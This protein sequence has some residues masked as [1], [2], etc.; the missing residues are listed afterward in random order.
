VA[1]I[2]SALANRPFLEM[3][4]TTKLSRPA[5]PTSS[6]SSNPYPS[7][8]TSDPVSCL[9][10]GQSKSTPQ[11]LEPRPLSRRSLSDPLP[12]NPSRRCSNA[13]RCSKSAIDTPVEHKVRLN[14]LGISAA[15]YGGE[16]ERARI[17]KRHSHPSHINIYTECG[18]HGDDWLFGG[19]SVIEAVKR[20]FEKK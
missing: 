6:D 5:P 14:H 10:G 16:E 20:I 13:H 9:A 11:R 7:R 18:R 8:V 1:L 15:S 12:F 17:T 3:A 19:F 4:Q 2:Q